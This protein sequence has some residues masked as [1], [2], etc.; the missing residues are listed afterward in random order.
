MMA[1]LKE[2]KVGAP[3]LVVAPLSTLDNWHREVKQWTD[4][5]MVLWGDTRCHRFPT[6][7]RIERGRDI[8]PG[9]RCPHRSHRCTTARRSAPRGAATGRVESDRVT[10]RAVDRDKGPHTSLAGPNRLNSSHT[11]AR[12]DPH[13]P[14]LHRTGLWGR[15]NHCGLQAERDAL[16]AGWGKVDVVITSFEVVMRDIRHF[17]M[18]RFITADGKVCSDRMLPLRFLSY[19]LLPQHTLL[20]AVC[21]KTALH[22]LSFI[23]DI[24]IAASL[25]TLKSQTR[26]QVVSVYNGCSAWQARADANCWKYLTIDEGHRLKNK[27]CR[28]VALE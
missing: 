18:P 12:M 26:G 10:E 8:S 19:A 20:A 22:S 3:Y 27:D 16:R 24:E 2:K 15:P 28:F 13:T 6:P 11:T 4:N 1:H 23:D 21:D 5:K 17:Q 25:R 7:A 9:P 14:E